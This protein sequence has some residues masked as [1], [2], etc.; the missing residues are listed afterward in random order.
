MVRASEDTKRV[1]LVGARGY[2]G[3]EL[4]ALVDAHPGF[5]LAYASSRELAGTRVDAYVEGMTSDVLFEEL[6]PGDVAQREVDVCVLALPNGLSD[7]FVDA[8][9][10]GAHADMHL[11]DLSADHRFVDAW[12]YGFPERR[13]QEIQGASR[14]ANPG[15]YA[16]GMQCGLLPI[17]DL[18]DGSP[19][20]FGVSG[21]SGAG[22]KPSPKNDVEALRD[23]LMPYA[24]VD[25][26][27]EREVSHQL[28]RPVHFMPHVAPFFRGITLTITMMLREGAT[29]GDV[30]ERYH[31]RFD[32]EPLIEL[33]D[34]QVPLV[35]D[36]ALRHTC[37]IGGVTV[38]EG[39]R[40]AVVV[41]TLDNLLKGAATQAMQNMNLMVGFDEHTGI[42]R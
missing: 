9:D 35:R 37:R 10:A 29:T 4:L 39:R 3:R 13:R 7:E 15:C 17:L 31:A 36:N 21:Y 22:T 24:L 8:I 25:H 11:V 20:I 41:V 14:V 30:L 32:A 33:L 26:T 12:V 23:N 42:P 34:E 5:E 6:T 38:H 1:G 19:Q 40:R 27:H 28:E 18:V 16:T 2:T